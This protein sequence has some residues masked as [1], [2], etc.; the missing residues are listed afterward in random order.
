MKAAIW[1]DHGSLDVLERPIPEPRPGWVRVKV[2][3][4]GICGTDLHFFR[5][6]FPSPKGLL[7][8]H[9]I[10]GVID[11]PGDNVNFSG[12]AAVAVEP[13]VSCGECYHCRTGDYNRCAKRMLLGVQ[14]RGGCAE[15][16]TVPASAVYL[17]PDG[18]PP[19]AGA[20]VEPLAVCVRGVRRGQVGS[21]HRVLII[22]AGSIGLISIVAARAAGAAEIF[23]L[24][25]HP[26]Q[27]QAARQLGADQVFPSAEAAAAHIGDL[28]IDCVIETVGGRADTLAQAV[29][30]VR[31]GGVIV[32]L[33]VFEGAA[34]IPALDFSTR[35]LTLV[36]SNC[37]ARAGAHSDF[38]IAIELLRKQ[39]APLTSI[40]THHFTLDRINQAFAAAADKS[41]GSIKVHITP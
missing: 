41:S 37:Y 21:G 5:G 29:P 7:P 22:G 6:A 17:L 16:A 14:G 36:A 27:Q 10:G 19:A 32:M 38:A 15:F 40:V 31:A 3:A 35:E 25:R 18:M 8:G 28:P 33:G 13:L 9:E 23:V 24:A 39:L 1:N 12:G 30:I 20:L 34:S 4:V 26:H 2:A 11:A